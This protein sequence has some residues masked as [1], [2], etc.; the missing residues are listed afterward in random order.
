MT[1]SEVDQHRIGAAIQAVEEKTAGEIV[2]VLA[3]A[4]SDYF[5]Y[6][7]AWAA[8]LS[9]LLPWLLVAFT[10]FSVV[11]I[12]LAQI[13]LF[14]VLFLIASAR[15]IR[16]HLVPRRARRALAHRAA[17]EQFMIRGL[18]RKQNRAAILIFVSLAEHY[19]R[20]VADDG[21]AAKVDQALWQDAV[22]ALLGEVKE[23][24]IAD[25]FIVAVEKCGAVL[26]QH[27]PRTGVE[28]E[29]PDRI[30]VI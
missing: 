22:D 25:G 26:A 23:G 14:T 1:I 4:A 15:G 11:Q 20:I 19:A 9:L 30:Y 10:E 2:C 6:A 24:R 5:A 13:V 12:L 18:A 16:H 3:R 28:D 8:L 29:L 7:T 27:F 17:M 21:I